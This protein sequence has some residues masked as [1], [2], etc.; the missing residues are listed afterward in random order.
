MEPIGSDA[1]PF[2]ET[3]PLASGSFTSSSPETA[4]DCTRLPA[5]GG[6]L[7]AGSVSSLSGIPSPSLSATTTGALVVDAGVGVGTAV[8]AAT[9]V[10]VGTGV[11]TTGSA[12]TC[13]G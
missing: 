5:I 10:G 7:P 6:R 2:R 1:E 8:D 3:N 13:S 12:A 11:G 4:T 9:G